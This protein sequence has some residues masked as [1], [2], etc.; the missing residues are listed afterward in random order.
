M[1]L[2]EYLAKDV[3]RQAQIPVPAGRMCQTPEEAAAVCS[4]IGP[5]ALKAQILAGARG[6]A[7]GI[8]FADT[9]EEARVASSRL[10]GSELRGF[11]VDRLLVEQKL[12]IDAELYLGLAV[13]GSSRRP[14]LIASAQGGMAIEE[15]PE[16]AIVKH[17]LDITWGLQ[18]YRARTVGRRLGLEGGLLRQFTDIALR[19]WGLFR[20]HDA[21]LVEINPLVVSGDRLVAADARLNVDD[22]ALFRHPGLPRVEEGTDLERRV[23]ELGLSFVQLDGDIAV[24]ANGAGITMATLDVLSRYGGKPANFLDAGG[25]AAAEPMAAAIEVLL[26][27]RPRAMLINIFGGITRCDEVARAILQVK[28]QRGGFPVPLVVRLVGTNEDQGAALLREQGISAYRNMEEA[29]AKVVDLA[30]EGD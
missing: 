1:K 24:M 15:V 11:R 12:A 29:A 28:E 14:V 3:F 2:Y 23:K 25:G 18:P 9:P 4:E 5:V 13:E 21:E 7:G 6:K 26:E 20:A 17:A 8:A 16:R 22:E 10:L 27:T 30:G 19:L